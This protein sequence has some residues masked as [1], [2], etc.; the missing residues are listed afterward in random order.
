MN[1]TK[2]NFAFWN[3]DRTRP[4]A[5]GTIKIDGVDASFHTSRIVTEIF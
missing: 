4:L 1:A 3:Y 2:L 5:D